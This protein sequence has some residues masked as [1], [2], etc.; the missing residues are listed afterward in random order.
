MWGRTNTP[1]SRDLAQQ[2]AG[3]N[4]APPTSHPRGGAVFILALSLALTALYAVFAP[5]CAAGRGP[6]G[7]VIVGWD[8]AQLPETVGELGQAAAGFLPPPW[9]YLAGAGA[10]ALTGYAAKKRGEDRGWDMAVGTQPQA[11][12]PAPGGNGVGT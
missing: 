8:V 2:C 7:E 10:L 9:N 6:A 5:G 11:K 1:D 4:N 12:P 3:A